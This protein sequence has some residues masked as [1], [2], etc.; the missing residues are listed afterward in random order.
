MGQGF[1]RLKALT[2]LSA[3]WRSKIAPTA[4]CER[5]L[6]I[7]GR[8]KRVRFGPCGVSARMRGLH[9]AANSN[10]SFK[11]RNQ[12]FHAEVGEDLSVPIHGWRFALS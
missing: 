3:I 10:L 11:E 2:G 6:G 5:G 8:L 7:Q 9:E 1:S 4:R 12:F